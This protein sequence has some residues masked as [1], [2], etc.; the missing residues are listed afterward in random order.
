MDRYRLFKESRGEA[1]WAVIEAKNRWFQEKA[2][3]VEE[4]QL[5]GKQVWN[6]VWDM[7]RGR[8]GQVSS[9]VMMR[10]MSHV[11]SLETTFLVLI[12]TYLLIHCVGV[13][14]PINSQTPSETLQLNHVV[15]S[16]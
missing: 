6:C 5:G 2:A 9:R 11:Q 10:M 7:Q 14:L 13:A 1:K 16:N 4:S 3:S 12:I 15:N 8:K